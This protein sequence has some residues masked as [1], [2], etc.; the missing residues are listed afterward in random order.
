MAAISEVFARH[1]VSLKSVLQLDGP[2]ETAN[3]ITFLTHVANEM[4]VQDAIR[5]ITALPCVDLLE[6]MIRAES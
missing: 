6:S 4:A 3:R 1:G 5:E 2:A